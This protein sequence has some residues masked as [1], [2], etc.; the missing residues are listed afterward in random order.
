MVP[1]QMEFAWKAQNTF[2]TEINLDLMDKKL[3]LAGSPKNRISQK[4]D[5]IQ[6]NQYVQNNVLDITWTNI[7]HIFLMNMLTCTPFQMVVAHQ[8]ME[9]GFKMPLQLTTLKTFADVP[10]QV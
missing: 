2:S 4:E 10:D 7:S 1:H 9:N 3:A 5:V 6:A 8:I